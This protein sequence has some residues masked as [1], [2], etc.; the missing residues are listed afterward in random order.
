MKFHVNSLAG[1]L[2]LALSSAALAQ[3][4]TQKPVTGAD[5][6]KATAPPAAA[7]PTTT[8]A[9]TTSTQSPKSAPSAVT[10]PTAVQPATTTP[11]TTPDEPT[12][13]KSATAPGQTGTTPGQEQTTPGEASQLTP[14]VTGQTPSGQTSGQ[15]AASTQVTAATSADV[16][17]GVS[18]FDQSGGLVGKVESVSGKNA[19]VSTG[20]AKASI[21]ISS[22]AKGD[23]GLVLSLTK[24][25]LDASAKEKTAA[26]AKPAKKPK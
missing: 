14:A 22:F 17:S 26:T 18:V 2:V 20:T 24:A 11:Q 6:K 8:T 21:P 4:V 7:A 19:V 10:S 5:R 15:A 12:P 3:G 23:K 13:G 9:P 16:K 25:Q 1:V